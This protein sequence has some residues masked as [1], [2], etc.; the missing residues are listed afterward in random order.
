LKSIKNHNLK[1]LTILENDIHIWQID[2][3]L[4]ITNLKMYWSY[5]NQNEKSRASKFRFEIQRV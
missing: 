5:L 3:E 1:Q 4:H 2:I